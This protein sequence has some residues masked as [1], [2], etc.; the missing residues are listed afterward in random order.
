MP[1]KE[2][3]KVDISSLGLFK[4]QPKINRV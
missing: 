1:S 2:A 3:V 4:I